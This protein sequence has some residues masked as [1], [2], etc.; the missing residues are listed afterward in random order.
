MIVCYDDCLLYN[1]LLYDEC[2]LWR[3]LSAMM[4]IVFYMIVCYIIVYYD[5]Y[6]LW[7]WLSAM[8]IVCY[9]DCLLW[10]VSD[11]MIVCY[12]ECLIWWLS[13]MMIIVCYADDCLLWW[14]S[15]CEF[16]GCIPSASP[17][18]LSPKTSEQSRP[19]DPTNERRDLWHHSP[20]IGRG[21]CKRPNSLSYSVLLFKYLP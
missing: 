17:L 4:M 3:C 1:C 19:A 9:D 15:V 10:W 16:V 20:L 11:M 14:S 6:L 13:A 12:D 21:L 7:R 8:I 18:L 2:L 5:E